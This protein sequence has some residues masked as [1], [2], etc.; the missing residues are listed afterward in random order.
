MGVKRGLK[1]RYEKAFMNHKVII[2]G[3]KRENYEVNK[4]GGVRCV[5]YMGKNC[6]RWWTRGRFPC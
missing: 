1:L 5:S 3:G 4:I 2:V 6:G